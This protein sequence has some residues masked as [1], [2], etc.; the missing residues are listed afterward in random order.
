MGEMK[1]RVGGWAAGLGSENLFDAL[2]ATIIYRLE[3]ESEPRRFPAVLVDLWGGRLQPD[4]VPAAR[5]ELRQIAR[6]LAAL[7]PDRGVKSLLGLLPLAGSGLPV[8]HCASHLGEVFLAPD[9][10]PLLAVLDE[11][12]ERCAAAGRPLLI[13]TAGRRG[14]L[15]WAAVVTVT[16]L[17]W[18]IPAWLT[19][20][21]VALGFSDFP[22][23]Q[24]RP[25]A[26]G[27]PVWAVG[28]CWTSLGILGLASAAF[29]ALDRFAKR[30]VLL[31]S[32]LLLAYL[33][34]VGWLTWL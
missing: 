15:S 14:N 4:R 9:G 17:A 6:E 30:Y 2:R 1:A 34:M 19:I 3:P 5:G 16:G 29:P 7:P 13:N 8:N 26:H 32:V 11:A 27:M 25:A 12:V 33:F 31:S 24:P 18:T 28:L 10:R 21:D 23:Q 22:S 20:P